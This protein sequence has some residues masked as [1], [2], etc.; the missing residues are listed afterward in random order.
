M[1]I[2][3]DII[4]PTRN[5]R[6]LTL[7]CVRAV[8]DSESSDLAL[9]CIV[10]DNGSADGTRDR[11]LSDVPQALVIRNEDNP[12]FSRACNQGANAGDGE[13][14]L[15]LNS[16]VIPLP[17]AIL[18]LAAFLRDNPTFVA[19]GGRIVHPATNSPQVG[20][21]LRGYPTLASQLALMLG[22]ERVWPTNR[23]SRRQLML[24]FDYDRTQTVEAQPA[25]ACFIC[26]RRDYEAIGGFDEGFYFWFEDV[27]LAWR[28]RT[29]GGI[30]YV[31]DAVF[32]HLGSETF[33]QWNRADLVVTRF[34]SQRRYFEK[35]RSS[36][37]VKVLRA[38]VALL[39]AVRA[40]PLT[41][42]S[43]EAS[44]AY[45]TVVREALFAPGRPSLSG[46]DTST[47]EPSAGGRGS[48]R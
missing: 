45:V 3:V 36:F 30:A 37:D 38:A 34:R 31:H 27:D 8:L 11:L 42:V 33:K 10:I 43:P 40:A 23:V 9:R 2:T 25:G 19:A 13:L 17:G 35:H 16:D 46:P 6:E 5:T 7:S 28:L 18:K 1:G 26:R 24:D 12:G 44:R 15:F 48:S 14:L 22:L 47:R 29:R 21:T 32:E 39:A 4:V 41:V 20:F